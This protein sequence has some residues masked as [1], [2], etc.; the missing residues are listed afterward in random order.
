LPTDRVALAQEIEDEEGEQAVA[1]KEPVL[2]A[3]R[4]LGEVELR[5]EG[6]R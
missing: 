1:R 5:D 3:R 4:Q 6:E 2:V